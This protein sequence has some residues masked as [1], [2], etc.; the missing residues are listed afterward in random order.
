MTD[1]EEGDSIAT[2]TTAPI[3]DD[4]LYFT[5]AL[6]LQDGDTDDLVA[7]RLALAAKESGIEDALLFLIP[8]PAVLDI[9]T[10]LSTMSLRSEQ[11]SSVSVHSRETQ[12]TTFTSL[13]SRSSRDK[14]PMSRM[15]PPLLR[16]SFSVDRNDAIAETPRSSM[17]H[18]HSTS[19]FSTSPSLHSSASS[20]Q[21]RSSRKQKRASA[22]F[23]LFRKEQRC[24]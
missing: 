3:F 24:V 1:A 8:R 5:E 6:L 2:L 19:G 7:S 17:R 22:L 16:A 11:R 4:R 12:S 15:P 13:P 18:R 9:S 20:M 14:S 10:A 21:G 23:S